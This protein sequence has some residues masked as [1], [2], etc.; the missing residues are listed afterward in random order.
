MEDK[1]FL[2]KCCSKVRK[3]IEPGE[4]LHRG[5][6]VL[7]RHWETTY[8]FNEAILYNKKCVDIGIWHGICNAYALKKLKLQTTHG[9]EP[10]KDFRDICSKLLPETKL[11]STID[12]LTDTINTDIIFMLGL[13][14]MLGTEWKEQLDNILQKITANYIIIRHQT[15]VDSKEFK[16]LDGRGREYNVLGVTNYN[17]SAKIEDVIQYLQEKQWKLIK[18]HEGLDYKTSNVYTF[19]NDN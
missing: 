19:Q 8:T 16:D 10:N 17:Q 2:F 14:P 7:K 13:I 11:Y 12:D 4:F 3:L 15:Y 9:F 1:K 6:D 18:K 5:T